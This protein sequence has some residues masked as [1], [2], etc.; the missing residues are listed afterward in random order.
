MEAESLILLAERCDSGRWP[1]VVGAAGLD[2]GLE[3]RLE[4]GL[5]VRL[6]VGL[7]V[8]RDDG[9]EGGEKGSNEV[10]VVS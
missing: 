6:E 8:G 10:K 9:L 4:V 7:E 3:V 1:L 2:V 5:E